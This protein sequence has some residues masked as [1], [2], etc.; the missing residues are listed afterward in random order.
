[1]QLTTYD[2]RH[3][4]AL[5][6]KARDK[7]SYVHQLSDRLS[8]KTSDKQTR[9]GEITTQSHPVETFATKFR[10]PT[11]G[12]LFD[13]FESCGYDRE[14]FDNKLLALVNGRNEN[15]NK[16][17]LLSLLQQIDKHFLFKNH[18]KKLNK[19]RLL[20]EKGSK[21]DQFKIAYYIRFISRTVQ[22][23]GKENTIK[24]KSLSTAPDFADCPETY[25]TLGD[26]DKIYTVLLDSGA[27]SSILPWDVFQELGI[28]SDKITKIRH[29]LNLQGTT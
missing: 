8:S 26:A 28:S 27:Q 21:I 24:I 18:R 10:T 7:E 22:H 19:F 13:F 2:I 29:C 20:V 16:I 1:M 6:K 15:E 12:L 17:Y 9:G 23:R 14:K 4:C 25:C 3:Q 11:T 5:F